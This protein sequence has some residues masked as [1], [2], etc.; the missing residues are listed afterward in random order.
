MESFQEMKTHVYEYK[1]YFRNNLPQFNTL[2]QYAVPHFD[3]T[4]YE[5]LDELSSLE[6]Y[7]K[8]TTEYL[9]RLKKA[10]HLRQLHYDNYIHGKHIED[11][12]HTAWRLGMNRLVE[13]GEIILAYW[14]KYSDQLFQEH[15]ESTPIVNEYLDA[16]NVEYE[17]PEKATVKKRK[18]TKPPRLSKSE[19][20]ARRRA[21]IE[22]L[23]IKDML[24][25]EMLD[26]LVKKNE[27]DY[28]SSFTSIKE[29]KLDLN[30]I[31]NE[32]DSV[33]KT[34]GFTG[35]VV[36]CMRENFSFR[37][38]KTPCENYKKLGNLYAG[39]C[40]QAD[41]I[42]INRI[43]ELIILRIE[44]CFMHHFLNAFSF[45]CYAKNL[46]KESIYNVMFD[47]HQ[48]FWC[49]FDVYCIDE[50]LCMMDRVLYKTKFDFNKYADMVDII[51]ENIH[52]LWAES[53]LLSRIEDME[54]IYDT[55]LRSRKNAIRDWKIMT[56]DNP[57]VKS[58][59]V[60]KCCQKEIIPVY[61]N[62]L[63]KRYEVIKEKLQKSLGEN[64]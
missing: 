26:Q 61:E 37:I 20:Q 51:K 10:A 12:G 6:L 22:R 62:Q 25:H 49:M 36:P 41:P 54:T 60:Y 59:D 44:K 58:V 64:F 3:K 46:D 45:F 5:N 48:A 1:E 17:P 39:F 47:N 11:P 16:L 63:K 28:G 29:C 34:E 56:H 24:E 7:K 31:L 13:E 57:S 55:S 4:A 33:I 42:H 53:C 8:E 19:M 35:S 9:K 15:V 18:P 23:Q 2:W 40:F 32:L 50:L 30:Q 27:E 43:S 38:K 14:C 21:R 52:Y